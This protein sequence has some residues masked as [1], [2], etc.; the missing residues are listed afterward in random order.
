MPD[1]TSRLPLLLRLY[2]AAWRERYGA[3]VAALLETEPVTTRLLLD[4][5]AGAIDARLTPQS[6]TG[7]TPMTARLLCASA[8]MSAEDR[9]RN[10]VILIG[11]SLIFALATVVLSV[12]GGRWVAQVLASLVFPLALVVAGYWTYLKP[13]RP[14]VR[15]RLMLIEGA[16]VL[17]I[18]VPA[19]IFAHIL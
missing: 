16:I 6:I 4:M 19:S 11:G 2:P 9:R 3:E 12:A 5:I 1:V 17:A 18:I 8:A 13:Y 7:G 15:I 14:A 10:N